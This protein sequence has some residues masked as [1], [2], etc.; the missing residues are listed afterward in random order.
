MSDWL[1]VDGK[2]DGKLHKS[3]RKCFS[4]DEL[5]IASRHLLEPFVGHNQSTHGHNKT[6]VY[7]LGN[8]LK[9]QGYHLWLVMLT[10]R[11]RRASHVCITGPRW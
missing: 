2:H 3:R 1:C 9:G 8:R 11:A 5:A 4:F 7:E 6:G 10:R